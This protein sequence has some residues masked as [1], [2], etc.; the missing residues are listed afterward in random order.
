MIPATG[1]LSSEFL[2]AR[3]SSKHQ[4]ESHEYTKQFSI[5]SSQCTMIIVSYAF[6][7]HH[8][9]PVGYLSFCLSFYLCSFFPF[10]RFP[11]FPSETSGQVLT[12]TLFCFVF[13]CSKFDEFAKFVVR[14][15]FSW[16]SDKKGLLCF[17]LR[18]CA[19][20]G[21]FL[22]THSFLRI[23]KINALDFRL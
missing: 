3:Y 9:Y 11:I 17:S 16:L 14:G 6:C 22:L 19:S 12:Y 15:L 18:L 13:S 20:A 23:G 2:W 1:I 5:I 7:I 4:H 10:S 21:V 8:V